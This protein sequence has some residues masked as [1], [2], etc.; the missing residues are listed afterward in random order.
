M[1]FDNL[2]FY[3]TAFIITITFSLLIL[4]LIFTYFDIGNPQEDCESIGGIPTGQHC[5]KEVNG[6]YVEGYT[7]KKG[8]KI[9]F[10]RN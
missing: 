2:F 7:I 9:I 10:V 6:E 4:F 8:D 1:K 5:A 3:I